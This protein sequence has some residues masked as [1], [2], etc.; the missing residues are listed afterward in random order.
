VQPLAQRF[1]FNP[2][3]LDD[4]ILVVIYI[5]IKSLRFV[6]LITL[7]LV[8]AVLVGL[9]GLL[10]LLT[11]LTITFLAINLK[12]NAFPGFTDFSQRLMDPFQLSNKATTSSVSAEQKQTLLFNLSIFV[13][14]FF[15]AVPQLTIVV[16]DQRLKADP[17]TRLDCFTYWHF[18]GE[19]QVQRA[20]AGVAPIFTTNSSNSSS[21][22]FVE[23]QFPAAVPDYACRLEGLSQIAT[24][25]IVGSAFI[26]AKCA[27]PKPAHSTPSPHICPTWR[28][29]LCVR[30]NGQLRPILRSVYPILYWSY[31]HGSFAKGLMTPIM[32]TGRTDPREELRRS[33]TN[34]NFDL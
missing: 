8:C 1:D 6:G 22:A 15:E 14:V 11:V 32:P 18:T 26:I 33:R 17:D 25:A 34:F 9:G 13:E 5:V 24:M 2:Q 7:Y 27:V 16:L 4:L 19:A 12:L 3:R 21:G 30:T 28:L 10:W 23:P 29:A 20:F 31:Q